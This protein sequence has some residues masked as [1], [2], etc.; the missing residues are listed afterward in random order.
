MVLTDGTTTLTIAESNFMAHSEIEMSREKSAG[1]IYK[2]QIGGERFMSTEHLRLTATQYRT[3][4]N[5]LKSNSDYYYY[6]PSYIPAEYSAVT[7]PIKVSFSLSSKNTEA[8]N[9]EV[10]YYVDLEIESAEFI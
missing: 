8:Y 6:T 5:I 4:L 1:G 9:G 10:I 2:M 7:F 3:L